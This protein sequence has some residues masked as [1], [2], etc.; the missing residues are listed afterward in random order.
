MFPKEMQIDRV[1]DDAALRR[2]QPNSVQMFS[3]NIAPAQY[4]HVESRTMHVQVVAHAFS[5]GVMAYFD[6]ALL[7]FSRIGTSVSQVVWQKR[8]VM[9]QLTH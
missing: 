5:V 9:P 2:V 7:E 3:S 1:E 8:D 4:D 6:A